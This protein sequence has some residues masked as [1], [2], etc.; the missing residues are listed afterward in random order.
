M[1]ISLSI[2]TVDFFNIEKAL[3]E[4]VLKT[5]YLHMDVMDGCFVPNLSFGP[6]VV[7]SLN[8]HLCLPLDTHLMVTHP[9]SY[10]EAF[11]KAGSRYITFH[12]ESEDDVLST[13]DEIR[14]FGALP[15][16]ALK[17]KTEIQTILPYL[18]LV[19]MVL[20]MTVNPGFGGQTLIP[21]T[22]DKVR[23]LN[24]MVIRRGLKTDIEVDGGIT[25]A[26]VEEVLAA[27]A[28][29]I[30]AGNAIYTGDAAANVKA[31]LEMM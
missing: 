21:Y 23:E 11:A 30:V 2:L 20:I 16:I 9:K 24:K 14:R 7:S 1:K 28:N 10:V 8:R 19:D 27:G 25:L 13:I 3:E 17:P 6:Q 12:V 18:P 26:N 29:I 22:L 31:F 15:G 5:D 4:L